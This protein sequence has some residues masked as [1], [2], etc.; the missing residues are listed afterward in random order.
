MAFTDYT[1]SGDAAASP[2][3][4]SFGMDSFDRES[5]V[6]YHIRD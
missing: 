5:L 2:S 1:N 3:F 4:Y 6:C